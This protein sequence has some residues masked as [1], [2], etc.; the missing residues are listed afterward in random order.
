MTNSIRCAR[1][2]A[3]ACILMSL[4]HVWVAASGQEKTAGQVQAAPQSGAPR[5]KDAGLPIQERVAYLPWRMT[6]E[7]KVDQL[8][9]GW[10]NK[11]EVVDPT[12][13][14][15][16]E[17]RSEEHTSELQSLRHLVCRL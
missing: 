7:E 1:P 3:F 13:T 17:T 8:A 16:N 12:G 15:T 10:E 14:Y 9:T 6:L 5:Y 4:A 2:Y 11:L